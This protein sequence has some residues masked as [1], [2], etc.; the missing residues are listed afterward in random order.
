MS[1]PNLQN[2]K[3]LAI[4]IE[5]DDPSIQAGLGPGPRRDGYILGVGIGTIDKQFYFPLAHQKIEHDEL[6]GKTEPLE[7][8]NKDNFY[9]WLKSLKHVPMV[10]ANIMYDADYLQ[11]QGFI[12]D[13]MHDIQI[14]GPLL[15]ENKKSYSLDALAHEWLGEGKGDQ[16]IADY[17]KR[18]GWAG[19]PQAHLA[20]MPASLVG[21]YCMKDC[22]QTLAIWNLQMPEIHAQ[23][24]DQVYSL[25]CELLHV[26]LY[27]RK[28]GVRVDMERLEQLK[29]AYHAI[30]DPLQA[31]LNEMCGF[32]ISVN[33]GKDIA[34]AFDKF[35]LSYE[36]SEK[37]NPIFDAIALEKCGSPIGQ[38]IIKAR[39]A[40]K[41]LSTYTEGFEPFIINGRI[42]AEFNPLRNVYDKGTVIGRFS[43]SNPS[44][45]V[46]P[47]AEE[48]ET[49]E[50]GNAIRSLFIPEENEDWYK[51]D[52]KQQETVIFFHYGRG[53]GADELR[54]AYT[55]NPNADTYKMIAA[56]YYGKRIED[57]DD[58]TRKIFKTIT[59]GCLYGM[60][61]DKLGRKMG[62][63]TL[64]EIPTITKTYWDAVFKAKGS[65]E[66][67]LEAGRTAIDI[68][69]YPYLDQYLEAWGK[70]NLIHKKLPCL[71]ETTKAAQEIADTR[72]YVK[73]IL[74]RRRRF[75]DPKFTYKAF[76]AVDSGTGSDI[77]KSAMI[78]IYKQGLLN[79][80]SMLITC[81]DDLSFSVPKTKEGR[82]AIMR[83]DEIMRTIIPLKIPLRTD[84]EYGPN[85][86]EVKK[87]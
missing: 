38:T 80:V 77:M 13:R 87:I 2:E 85:W 17:C 58:K 27:M 40:W 44:L 54:S 8:V 57:I 51:I 23:G 47:R 25:E 20:K 79:D 59:L 65:W 36:V 86:G 1:F 11:Y 14:C 5:T 75:D 34:K 10:G 21:K 35:G 69:D 4:D 70:L 46:I 28:L 76:Q 50:V 62:I 16:E 73:T 81:H 64:P 18:R 42:H 83:V 24:L 72:G 12:P 66:S 45:Q 60:G 53:K 3:H 9:A 29:K 56:A 48:D 67:K 6:F 19:K 52:Y 49:N 32:E 84:I 74:G 22:Q 61:G 78:E 71:K 30:F 41:M 55:N 43:S 82:E 33:S 26:L 37:D 31:E 39:H 63:I 7:N 68:Q 15:D